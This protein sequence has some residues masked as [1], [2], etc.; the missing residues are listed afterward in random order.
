M[1][2]VSNALIAERLNEYADILEQ[3]EANR[4]RVAAY[5]RGALDPE[6][7]LQTLPGIGPGLAPPRSAFRHHVS[8]GPR[9]EELLDVDHE[10]GQHTVVTETSGPLK[11]RRVVDGREAECR[12]FYETT[13]A[14][15]NERG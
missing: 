3:Q 10:E 2:D 14:S 6:T 8:A 12:D 5:R 7:L 4:F 11:G 15:T 1:P 9:V 13:P